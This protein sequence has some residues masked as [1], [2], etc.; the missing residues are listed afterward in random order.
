[1][2]NNNNLLYVKG[3][4]MNLIGVFENTLKSEGL[5]KNTVNS[6]I[7]SLKNV[8]LALGDV[9]KV[10]DDDMSVY[11]NSLQES[12]K[13]ARSSAVK[14]YSDFAYR[15]GCIDKRLF[16]GI[17]FKNAKQK[18]PEF[19]SKEDI[20]LLF[21]VLDNDVKNTFPNLEVFR[22]RL[23]IY[24][25][26]S[27]ALRVGELVDIKEND[28]NWNDNTIKI[29]NS[30]SG[31]RFVPMKNKLSEM[32]SQWLRMKKTAN[33]KAPYIFVSLGK[34]HKNKKL[35]YG[36]VRV[37]VKRCLV[38]AGLG[39]Y[40]PH[41]LRHSCANHLLDNGLEISQISKLLGHSS[42]ETTNT[43]YARTKRD[44]NAINNALEALA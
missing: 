29:L 27:C 14:R 34:N 44:D 9:L 39:K 36:G 25:Q 16:D 35:S 11:L 18:Q 10:S 1:M 8:E 30:K 43:Y 32:L 6:Y 3:E 28:I 2:P 17:T 13:R 40:T 12:T 23:M 33:I 41:Q 4:N 42:I 15:S 26:Y 37:I 38:E 21:R 22:N 24:L 20:E 5:S 19:I 7:S 31:P